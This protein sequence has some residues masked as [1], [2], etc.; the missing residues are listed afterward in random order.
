[1]PTLQGGYG[2]ALSHL[3]EDW[4]PQRTMKWSLTT[5]MMILAILTRQEY[6]STITEMRSHWAAPHFLAMGAAQ[7]NLRYTSPIGD[8]MSVDM[9]QE[10]GNLPTESCLPMGRSS[11]RASSR[12]LSC[13]E[14]H[15]LPTD[16][17]Q[18]SE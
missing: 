7:A 4:G 3:G 10:G 17:L 13:Q 14:P 11:Q 5:Q 9:G 1:M 2:V 6:K 15:P 16:W 12:W 18:V 8:E